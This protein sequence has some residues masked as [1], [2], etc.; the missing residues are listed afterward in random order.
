MNEELEID[1]LGF[2][3]IPEHSETKWPGRL[4]FSKSEGGVL[5]VFQDEKHEELEWH[6]TYQTIR[7]SAN[8]EAFTLYKSTQ[9][10]KIQKNG[11]SYYKL[12]T[13]TIVSGHFYLENEGDFKFSE[14]GVK[15]SN[16]DEWFRQLKAYEVK[17][18]S[19]KNTLLSTTIQYSTGK[20][21][22]A[23]NDLL[24]GCISTG[25]NLHHSI[26]DFNTRKQL[27]FNIISKDKSLI[28]YRVLMKHMGLLRVF[29]SIIFGGRCVYEELRV[30]RSDLK[31]IDN[32]G[33]LY[34]RNSF[35]KPSKGASLFEF[36]NFKNR[37]GEIIEKWFNICEEMPEVINLL[38]TTYTA[39]PIYDYHFRESYIALAGL[40]TWKTGLDNKGHIIPSLINSFL[41]IPKFAEIVKG[42]KDWHDIAR[43]NRNFQIHLNKNKLDN[44]IIDTPELVK[45]MRKIEAIILC[46]ILKELGFSDNE[47][48]QVFTKVETRFIFNFF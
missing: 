40:Y 41:H 38:Y 3:W 30:E 2:W 43:I 22:F 15:F 29:F 27:W 26:N 36:E 21:T 10:N 44:S 6:K 25:F 35:G 19:D 24:E 4:T 42:Y 17:D 8:G 9:F 28:S 5:E 46:H 31:N 47:I 33:K 34:I 16:V 1:V 7:G 39:N 11:L 23:I 12:K 13:D 37:L 18:V 45:L 32:I 48:N 14:L 20:I